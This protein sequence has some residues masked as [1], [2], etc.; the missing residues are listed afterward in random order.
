MACFFGLTWII[1]ECSTLNN[2]FGDIS[3]VHLNVFSVTKL[4]DGQLLSLRVVKFK[5]EATFGILMKLD[6]MTYCSLV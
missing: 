1:W 3:L 4:F 5:L 2:L 6:V